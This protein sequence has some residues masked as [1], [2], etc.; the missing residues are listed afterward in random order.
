MVACGATDTSGRSNVS[1]GGAQNSND[2]GSQSNVPRAALNTV[3]GSGPSA[4]TTSCQL[5]T[6]P[7]IVM[8]DPENGPSVDNGSFGVHAIDCIVTSNGPAFNVSAHLSVKSKGSVTI[9]G[10]FQP[11]DKTKPVPQ[12]ANTTPITAV[13]V[14]ADTGTFRQMDCSAWYSN[15][16]VNPSTGALQPLVGVAPGRVWA[17]VYCPTAAFVG[18]TTIH[19]ACQ[20]V[21]E[22][23]LENCATQ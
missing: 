2:G 4:P 17:T 7:V 1:D 16:L 5:N 6:Q 13:W 9:S 10:G 20:A 23:K 11:M 19:K 21:G 12:Q 15:D 18:D 8:G 22:F 14:L 3:I